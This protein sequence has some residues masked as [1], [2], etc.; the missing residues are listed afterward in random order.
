MIST[1]LFSKKVH[2]VLLGIKVQILKICKPNPHNIDT[3]GT[4]SGR[5]WVGHSR[6][7]FLKLIQVSCWGCPFKRI[8]LLMLSWSDII[9]KGKKIVLEMWLPILPKK[10]WILVEALL[11]ICIPLPLM[12]KEYTPD[13]LLWDIFEREGF[14][15]IYK[16][17]KMLARIFASQSIEEAFSG[18]SFI[19]VLVMWKT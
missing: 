18:R 6:T 17:S 12:R 10:W 5:P 9:F 2:L 4:L 14:A 3:S 7:I 11:A 19:M 13:R 8:K 15:Y 16:V 1:T